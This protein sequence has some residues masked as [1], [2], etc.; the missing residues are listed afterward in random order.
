MN[1][2]TFFIMNKIEDGFLKKTR[3][4][5]QKILL[6]CEPMSA[7]ELIIQL[8]KKYATIST[9]FNI[10]ICGLFQFFLDLDITNYAD[11]NTPHSTNINLN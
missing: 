5:R 1:K 7:S 6:S 9:L 10:F 2:D 3:L 8:R 11:D 4:F